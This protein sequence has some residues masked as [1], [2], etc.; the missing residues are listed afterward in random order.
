MQKRT[1]VERILKALKLQQPDVVPHFDGVDKKVRD[2][3]MRNSTAS[4][5]DFIEYLDVDGILISDRVYTWSYEPLGLSKTGRQLKRCQWGATIQFTAEETGIPMEPAIKSFP[6]LDRYVPPDPNLPWRYEWLK[7]VVKRFKGQKAIIVGCTDV[8]DIAKENLLGDEQYYSSM[9]KNPSFIDEVNEIALTYQLQYVKS[10]IDIG[11][12]VIFVNGDWAMTQGPMVS[13]K[14]TE[15][16]IAPSFKKIVEY[17]HSRR[18]P[19]IKH[20]DGNIWPIYDIIIH[21]GADGIHPIDPM[22]GM[23]IGEAKAK[24]GDRVC[25][26]G[27]VSCAF[28]LVSGTVE[29]VKQETKEV[30]RKGGKGGGFI[31][32]SSNS[33]HS[34]VKPEN[35]VAMVETIREF[36][37]YPLEDHFGN[38]VM[39]G[40]GERT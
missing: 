23:D 24:F 34:S 38:L 6:E 31:C 2:A 11:A 16:Y 39:A 8:F 30:I 9:V 5:E 18:I 10:C 25:L 28:S 14:F 32:M 20:T 4:Y 26:C 36:G 22:A 13:R 21:A 12:D 35:Y 15:R 3:I 19:V 7:Q 17:A 29:E 27:N 33:I 40:S 37:R 1:G